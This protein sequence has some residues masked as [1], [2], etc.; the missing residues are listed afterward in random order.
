MMNKNKGN[1]CTDIQTHTYLYFQSLKMYCV[2]F[3][4]FDTIF[5][6]ECDASKGFE[7]FE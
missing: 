2:L 1:N 7:T 3:C 5:Q 6:M 4:K